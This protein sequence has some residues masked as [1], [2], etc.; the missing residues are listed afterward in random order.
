MATRIDY[1][2]DRCKRVR[3]LEFDKLPNV[4]DVRKVILPP[5]WAWIE[6]GLY[7]PVC[8][9]K[10]ACVEDGGAEDV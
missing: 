1:H 5:D 3:C 7:C 6:E 4:P 9:G 2:C 8:K 10:I